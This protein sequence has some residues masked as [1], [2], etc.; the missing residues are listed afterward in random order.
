MDSEER[1]A[2]LICLSVRMS[3]RQTNATVVFQ[4]KLNLLFLLSVIINCSEDIDQQSGKFSL[5]SQ[6]PLL[7][8]I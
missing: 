2:K 5:T 8:Y 3:Q 6:K 4:T 1:I 7:N